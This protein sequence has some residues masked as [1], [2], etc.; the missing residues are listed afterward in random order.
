MIKFEYFIRL[1]LAAMDKVPL[2]WWHDN[3][4]AMPQLYRMAC[5]YLTIP[6]SSIPTEEANLAQE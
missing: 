3:K 2:Q 6:I 5:N 1:P 4:F